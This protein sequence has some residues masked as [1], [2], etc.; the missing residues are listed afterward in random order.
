MIP[1]MSLIMSKYYKNYRIY[2]AVWWEGCNNHWQHS[3]EALWMSSVLLLLVPRRRLS[4]FLIEAT[5][6]G[7]VVSYP[8]YEYSLDWP[9]KL[10]KSF[11]FQITPRCINKLHQTKNGRNKIAQFNWY[12]FYVRHAIMLSKS[13]FKMNNKA[14]VILLKVEI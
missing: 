11:W 10:S 12:F 2:T 14:G 1:R 8:S 7:S 6:Y 9:I 13:N 5:V 4:F 3:Y